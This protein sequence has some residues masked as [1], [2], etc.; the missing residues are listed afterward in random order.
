MEREGHA[1]GYSHDCWA[2]DGLD[3]HDRKGGRSQR[4]EA[5][6]AHRGEYDQPVYGRIGGVDSIAA[7]ACKTDCGGHGDTAGGGYR[8]GYIPDDLFYR[9]T[10]YQAY[11]IISS[12]FRGLGDSKSPMYFIAVAC[13][14]NI[15][16]DYVFIGGLHLGAAGAALGTTLSQ[17]Y[18]VV[19][20][21]VGA[22][23]VGLF[24]ADATV[25]TMGEEYIRSYIWDC[26]IAGIHFCFSGYFCAYGMSGI[27]FLYTIL[28]IICVRVPGAYFASLYF[29]DNLYP[30]RLAAPGGSLLSVIVCLI[31]FA[32]LRKCR[33]LK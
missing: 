2:G 21:F 29:P 4:I 14:V 13:G 7:V 9:N 10:A 18:S 32:V 12:I 20:Q 23:V 8:N 30:M 3:C 28:S 27:P 26:A 33:H 1:Y 11:N 22:D 6:I 19:T 16:L 17:T 31:A 24:T 25:V 5:R 15:L